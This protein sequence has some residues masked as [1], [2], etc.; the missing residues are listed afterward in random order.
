MYRGARTD[1]DG[2]MGGD[3]KGDA[4]RFQT[5]IGTTTFGAGGLHPLKYVS[6][7]STFHLTRIVFSE[8]SLAAFSSR[9]L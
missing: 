1:G 7:T 6:V 5:G 3:P 4:G 8:V 2:V 9:L